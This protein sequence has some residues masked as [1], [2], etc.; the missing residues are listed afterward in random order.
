MHSFVSRYHGKPILPQTQS[1]HSPHS[2]PRKDTA[3]GAGARGKPGSYFE[4]YCDV[5]RDWTFLPRKATPMLLNSEVASEL[6]VNFG[7]GFEPRNDAEMPERVL[8]A[9][10][11]SNLHVSY[12]DG[13]DSA[14]DE[15]KQ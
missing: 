3:A 4:I 9:L 8:A 11:L 14:S 5:D 13:G 6:S 1:Y 12:Q 15:G 10:S 7:F 2:W